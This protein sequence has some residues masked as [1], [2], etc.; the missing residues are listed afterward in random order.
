MSDEAKPIGLAE[1]LK[2]LRSELL[3]VQA[4]GVDSDLKLL[5]VA[6]EIELKVVVTRKGEVGGGVK[7][8]VYNAEAKGSLGDETT[9]TIRLN[10]RPVAAGDDGENPKPVPISGIE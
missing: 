2:T 8:W 10:L 9:Q 5:V 1:M 3:D 6:A 7:F 4:D